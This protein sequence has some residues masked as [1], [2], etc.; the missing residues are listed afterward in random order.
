MR[1]ERERKRKRESKTEAAAAMIERGARV[2]L[3]NS[4]DRSAFPL[5]LQ[6]A[7]VALSLLPAFL[8]ARFCFMPHIYFFSATGHSSTCSVNLGKAVVAGFLESVCVCVC[9]TVYIDVRVGFWYVANGN[10]FR[11]NWQT[12]FTVPFSC[13][14]TAASISDPFA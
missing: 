1:G 14:P 4:G 10:A 7:A 6:T 8:V 13:W 9:L 5:S 12:P 11:Y 2:V 3:A